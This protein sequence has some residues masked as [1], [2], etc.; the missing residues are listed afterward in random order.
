[1]FRHI[2]ASSPKFNVVIIIGSLLMY[3][4]ALF[5]AL[6]YSGTLIENVNVREKAIPAFCE[7]HIFPVND[8]VLV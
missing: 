6:S 3:P 1:M 5:T 8:L 4:A 7:V 2:K